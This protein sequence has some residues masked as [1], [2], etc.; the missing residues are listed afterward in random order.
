MCE[1]LSSGGERVTIPIERKSSS[2]TMSPI[3]LDVIKNEMA[4]AEE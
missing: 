3:D 4:F 2:L 1:Y